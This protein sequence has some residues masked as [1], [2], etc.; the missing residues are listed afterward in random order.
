MIDGQLRASDRA[1]WRTQ[2]FILALT[3]DAAG[4]GQTAR[5]I[6]A[7]AAPTRS[8]PSSPGWRA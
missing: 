2:A 5:E 1:A 8:P 3:G 6:D 4:A 7:G